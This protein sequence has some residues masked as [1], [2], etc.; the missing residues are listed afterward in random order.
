MYIVSPMET[1]RER[2]ERIG[3]RIRAARKRRGMSQRQLAELI[4]ARAGIE[5]ETARR[6]LINHETG[7]FAPRLRTLE[8]IA[9]VTEQPLEF[10]VGPPE[11]RPENGRFR[12]AA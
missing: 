6:S 11:V 2:A 10:F 7:R 5:P 8:V 9:E 3:D 12:G 1:T 4:A